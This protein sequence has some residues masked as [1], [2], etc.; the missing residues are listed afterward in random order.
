[1][2]LDIEADAPVYAYGVAGELLQVFSNL[3]SNA[4]DT[5]PAESRIRI[6]IKQ[7]GEQA[8]V[9]IA[10]MGAGIAK[11]ARG[12]I[13]EPFFT[14]KKDIGTGLGLWVTKQLVEK[15]GGSIRFRSRAGREKNGTVFV[16]WLKQEGSA[17]STT[18]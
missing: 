6:R 12:Q 13:F 16:V 14:T 3:L 1:V 10:D 17:R 2:T 11:D 7:V 8:Q 5:S 4:M 9:A 18:A 15:H